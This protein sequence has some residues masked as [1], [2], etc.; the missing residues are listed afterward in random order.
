MSTHL[1]LLLQH[2]KHI[3]FTPPVVQV[4]LVDLYANTRLLFSRQAHQEGDTSATPTAVAAA[5]EPAW[6]AVAVNP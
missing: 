2:P 1:L 6:Q 3:S 5:A 4:D